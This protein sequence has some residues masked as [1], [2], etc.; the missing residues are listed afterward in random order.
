MATQTVI[1][2]F[3]MLTDIVGSDHI[4]YA[5]VENTE[6]LLKKLYADFPL[7][8]DHKFRI[9]VDNNFIEQSTD[10]RPGSSIALMPPFS[11]G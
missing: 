7:L 10:I 3:G 6:E 1:Q 4:E 9:A 5:D 11:G 2:L 8:A